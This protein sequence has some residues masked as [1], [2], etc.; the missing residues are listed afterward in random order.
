M[1]TKN[2]SICRREFIGGLGAGVALGLAGCAR[3]GGRNPAAAASLPPPAVGEKYPGWRPGELDIH[4]IQTGVGEQTF[5]RIQIFFLSGEPPG[6]RELA[7]RI[8]PG[9]QELSFDN[10]SRDGF[11]FQVLPAAFQ[12]EII[13]A[14]GNAAGLD[15]GLHGGDIGR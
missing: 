2:A 15:P 14:G 10:F 6:E 9:V 3:A 8:Q 1:K 5:E 4:F 7:Q 13:S 11:Q 12:Q